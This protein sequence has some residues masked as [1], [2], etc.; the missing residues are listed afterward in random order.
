MTAHD[1][2][3]PRVFAGML[4]TALGLGLGACSEADPL[5][6]SEPDGLEALSA[7]QQTGTVG[8]LTA[9]APRV[10]V[11]DR[12]GNPAAGVRVR[13]SVVSGEGE[14]EVRTATSDGQGIASA[15]GWT[16]GPRVGENQVMASI[17]NVAYA[18]F[19]AHAEPGPPDSLFRSRGHRI[20]G[21]VGSEMDPLP[22]LTVGDRFG[23]P[24]E[25]VPVE[26]RIVAGGG[27][28]EGGQTVTNAL[29]RASP[30][31]WELGTV[32]GPHKLEA[33]VLDLPPVLFEI[34]GRAA[35]PDT[36]DV[37]TFEPGEPRVGDLIPGLEVEIVD[38][39]GNPV[40]ETAL[41]VRVLLGGGSVVPLAPRT[42]TEGRVVLDWTL[43]PVAGLQKLELRA[44]PAR[45]A[46]V[47]VNAAPGPAAQLVPI[48]GLDQ[49]ATA[50]TPVPVP[51]AA[52]ITDGYGNPVEGMEVTFHVIEGGGSITG[53][54]VIGDQEGLARVGSWTL[55]PDPGINRLEARHADLTPAVFE[56]EG[57]EMDPR[58]LMILAGDDQEGAAGFDAPEAP[59]V[60]LLDSGGQPV[61][62]ETVVFSVIEGNGSVTPSQVVTN[63]QG[64]AYTESWTLGTNPGWNRVRAAAIDAPA[65]TFSARGLEGF[66]VE[67]VEVHLN[68]GSQ[69]FPKSIPLLQGRGG[70]LRVFLQAN[71]SND[72]TP[73]VRILLYNG[74]TEIRSFLVDAPAS[75]VPT[76]I[77]PNL[78]SASWS[79]AIPAEDTPAGMGL[80]VV[81]DEDEEMTIVDRSALAWP[82]DGSIHR[83]DVRATPPFRSTF[84]R[85]YSENLDTTADLDST[86]VDG[87]AQ[88]TLDLFP[89]AAS[90]AIMRPG[91]Y[92]SGASPLSGSDQGEG[93]SDL[94]RE[95]YDL[96]LLD[97]GT[98]P[99]AL[100]RYYHG[101]LRRVSGP[102][103]AGIA[104]VATSPNSNALAA[105]SHDGAGSRSRVVAHEFGHNFGRWHAPCG[106]PSANSIDS[107]YPH[108]DAR[109]G[110]TG[111][112]LLSGNLRSSDGSYRDI[113]AYCTPEWSSDYTFDAVFAMRLARP[114]GAPA[115]SGTLNEGILVSGEWSRT[116]G[117][118]LDPVARLRSVP[119]S[120]GA[121]QAEI[122][123]YDGG[124]ALLFQRTVEG[125]PLDHA[126]DPTLRH[127]SVF[128]P[129]APVDREALTRVELV[130]PEGSAD[131]QT[132]AGPAGAS[133]AFPS[134]ELEVE[135][136]AP[137]PGGAAAAPGAAWLQVRWN[138][139][140][141]PRAILR[142]GPSGRVM[143]I[144]RAGEVRIPVPDSGELA[145]EFSDG[146]RTLDEVVRVR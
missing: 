52:R 30:T 120:E 122:R 100:Q 69:T 113:M 59:A 132:T 90:S 25:G 139:E 3:R 40:T 51:P 108:S 39:F 33:R 82:R 49:I 87:Y 1:G 97:G 88:A 117:A 136:V 27:T 84:V 81:V 129:L 65:V 135:E 19:R 54:S 131:R 124:G 125:L 134:P 109:I 13:F 145:V 123:G 71:D 35:A 101:I 55:G 99:A 94:L 98:D 17:D 116:R 143:S 121:G 41:E 96:R 9:D 5:L 68:Q 119:M 6:F 62:G 105:V 14:I 37:L 141:F 102:G 70:L 46:T 137:P 106:G 83:P 77:D 12:R 57:R 50:G 47:E 92:V 78:A 75:S 4:A 48:D 44:G 133:G 21:T 76:T 43:G 20:P 85:I 16:L 114:V 63:A 130:S 28:L 29:G 34:D 140:D 138:V 142:D 107:D 73:A 80:R 24:L 110:S 103:I 15:E 18:P 128:V 115:T 79:V 53:A 26:F 22:Q 104:Y 56:A 10:R 45:W 91:T 112:S 8:E 86:N 67:V 127:F 66:Q 95:I 7:T 36:V 93:W 31:R 38:R 118:L 32:A 58:Q 126:D 111:Y 23:N 11:I 146:V 64:E 72:K 2:I 60:L 42:D 61:A 89:I 144:A 74:N